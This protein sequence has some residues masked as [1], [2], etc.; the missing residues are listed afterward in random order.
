MHVQTIQLIVR[1]KKKKEWRRE[2]R[3]TKGI[4][5]NGIEYIY[6]T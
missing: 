1:K 2:E 5:N 3:E 4:K 6:Y